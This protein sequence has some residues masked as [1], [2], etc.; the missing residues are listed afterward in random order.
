MLYEQ[1]KISSLNSATLPNCEREHSHKKNVTQ[2][3]QCNLPLQFTS[4]KL[5]AKSLSQTNTL[6]QGPILL[7]IHHCTVKTLMFLSLTFKIQTFLSP[8]TNDNLYYRAHSTVWS[9]QNVEHL[10]S[11]YSW[12]IT[13]FCDGFLTVEAKLI[14]TATCNANAIWIRNNKHAFGSSYWRMEGP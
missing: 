14:S 3:K 8:Q 7:S 13:W 10:Q 12:A 1:A 6:I 11:R 9:K 5:A 2:Y 4:P